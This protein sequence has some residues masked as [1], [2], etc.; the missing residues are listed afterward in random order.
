MSDVV[1]SDLTRWIREAVETVP[2]VD[3]HTHLFPPSHNSLMRWGIDDLLTYHYLVSEMFVTCPPEELSPEEFFELSKRDQADQVWQRLFVNKSPLSEA[4]RGVITT[5]RALGFHDGIRTKR[6]EEIRDY[7][8][9]TSAA[10][11]VETVFRLA[12]VKYVVMT[13]I[14][15]DPEEVAAW[16]NPDAHAFEDK[17]KAAIRVDQILLGDWKVIQESLENQGFAPT[18]FG[19]REFLRKWAV[20]TNAI[21]F[22]ASTPAGFA[23][24]RTASMSDVPPL[25]DKLPLASL[26]GLASNIAACCLLDYV[27]LPV[28]TELK[29]PLGLKLGAVRGLNP[30]LNACGGGDGVESSDLGFVSTLARDHPKLKILLTVLSRESQFELAVLAS[31]FSNLHVY[32]CW[33]Y[34]NNPSIIAPTTALRLELLGT[35][36]T[37]QHSDAR[38]LDQLIYKWKHSREVLSQVLHVKYT[39]LA[40]TGWPV[41]QADV[42]RDVEL[43]LGGSFHA[44]MQK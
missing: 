43:L 10:T 39:N 2:V 23:Y 15:F 37:A 5:L 40:A 30:R 33:W 22:M 29:L 6:L 41:T 26:D 9:T 20:R 1:G 19:A 38:V 28:A 14:P 44:F 4:C 31:K 13:N 18:V 32:G 16:D 27:L 12:N 11:F 42:L 17:F 7:F 8:F 35:T 3:V 25:D 24:Q 21:Y 36:F 34:C